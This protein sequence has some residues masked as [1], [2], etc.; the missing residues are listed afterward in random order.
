MG[1]NPDKTFPLSIVTPTFQ[2]LDCL[3]R[4]YSSLLAQTC[5][6]FEWVVVDDG[7]TDGSSE[8]VESI[9]D[10][11]PFDIVLIRKENGGKHT[12]LN[13]AFPAIR[14]RYFAVA[15][16]DDTLLAEA[17][18]EILRLVDITEDLHRNA[19]KNGQNPIC[20]F[21]TPCL[22]PDKKR[23]TVNTPPDGSI[24]DF[25]SMRSL[26]KVRGDTF[27][28]LKTKYIRH[29]RFPEFEGESFVGEFYLLDSLAL[30]YDIVYFDTPL[31][32]RSYG[33]DGLSANFVRLLMDSP[34]STSLVLAF[35]ARHPRQTPKIRAITQ[36]R[37]WTYTLGSS[38]PWKERI[39][40]IGISALPM[41][42]PALA[43][44][45]YYTLFPHSKPIL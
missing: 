11:S 23:I 4:L 41:L 16:S 13:R 24:T 14:G 15:D 35:H 29:F 28:V 30:H 32:V 40:A 44:K 43:L 38:L 22:F 3:R 34:R 39:N 20:G 9:C 25:V 18:S 26:L 33:D 17:V 5:H 7:S 12:A 8:W 42:L 10:S 37:Y 21:T 31:L 2:R 45:L 6:D 19:R 27:D 36:I 1:K